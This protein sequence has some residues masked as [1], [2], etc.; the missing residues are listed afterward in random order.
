MVN[1]IGRVDDAWPPNLSESGRPDRDDV[2]PICVRL[3]PRK[4]HDV[5]LDRLADWWR[6]D[7]AAAHGAGDRVVR[8]CRRPMPLARF[9]G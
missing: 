8:W 1:P 6:G 4:T 3:F 5:H 7:R 9:D 2:D